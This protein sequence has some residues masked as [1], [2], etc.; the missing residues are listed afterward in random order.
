MRKAFYILFILALVA[1]K[2]KEE[3]KKSKEETISKE[4]P[5]QLYQMSEMASFMEKMYA[6]HKRIKSQIIAGEKV[7][8]LN[9]EPTKLFYARMT[10]ST[11]NDIFYQE[12]AKLFVEYEEQ[13]LE[14][15]LS[16]KEIYN[17]AVNLCISCHQIKCTGPIPRI[18]KLLIR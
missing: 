14:D 16:Q 11:D 8:T 9:F 4:E 12:K 7:D 17:K 2:H 3:N 1:C 10:D 13:L 18:K 6:D 15:S 5:F